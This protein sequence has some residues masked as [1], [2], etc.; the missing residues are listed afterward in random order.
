[1]PHVLY[2]GFLHPKLSHSFY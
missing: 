1:L 2:L